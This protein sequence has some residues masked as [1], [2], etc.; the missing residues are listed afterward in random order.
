MSKHK[1][2]AGPWRRSMNDPELIVTAARPNIIVATIATTGMGHAV[3]PNADM[4]AAA[5]EMLAA[6]ERVRNFAQ[7]QTDL[8]RDD[9]AIWAHVV[10]MTTESI[11]KAK[12]E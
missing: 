4:I 11:A 10:S 7:Y 12:G 1:H 2:T 5:P 8:D 3:D 9:A 6:L